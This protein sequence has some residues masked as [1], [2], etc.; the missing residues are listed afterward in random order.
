MKRMR[1]AVVRDVAKVAH[2]DVSEI[3]SKGRNTREVAEARQLAM[4]VL[5][6]RA[7]TSLAATAEAFRRHPSTVTFAVKKIKRM[8][9]KVYGFKSKVNRL[10]RN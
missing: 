5:H 7:K 4:Y 2:V 6:R 1:D 8:M 9:D 10:V 3:M